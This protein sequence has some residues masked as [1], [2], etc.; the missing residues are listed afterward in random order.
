M[1]QMFLDEMDDLKKTQLEFVFS[2]LIII[3]NK[4][5]HD[6]NMKHNWTIAERYVAVKWSIS[7]T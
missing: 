4:K 1:L 2:P 7:T 3:L 5:I 6:R